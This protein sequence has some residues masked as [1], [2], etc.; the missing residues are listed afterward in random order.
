MTILEIVL[1]A[2]FGPSVLILAAA[3]WIYFRPEVQ[4][5]ALVFLPSANFPGLKLAL[6]VPRVG[7]PN[8]N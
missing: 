2:V 5:K 8:Y 4:S 6:E 3:T 1:A 7:N